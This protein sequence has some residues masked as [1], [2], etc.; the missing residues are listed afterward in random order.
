MR[1]KTISVPD[2]PKQAWVAACGPSDEVTCYVGSD[3][4]VVVRFE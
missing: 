3:V 1:L 4:E 2:W